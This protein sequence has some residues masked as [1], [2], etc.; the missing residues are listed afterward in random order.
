MAGPLWRPFLPA[1]IPILITR[2][3]CRLSFDVMDYALYYN[4]IMQRGRR[5][6]FESIRFKSN[7]I[8]SELTAIK[9]IIGRRGAGG[10]GR[11]EFPCWIAANQITHKGMNWLIPSRGLRNI[12]TIRTS[13]LSAVEATTLRPTLK[14]SRRGSQAW[15]NHKDFWVFNWYFEYLELS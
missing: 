10:C 11:M 6:I 8:V 9:A 1:G 13:L 4:R 14:N 7:W 2:N 5:L 12:H 15:E 3:G